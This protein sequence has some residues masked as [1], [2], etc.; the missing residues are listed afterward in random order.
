MKALS[1]H[2]PW[3][4][5]IFA[6]IKKH[7]TR[8]WKLSPAVVGVPIAL[9]AAKHDSP[10]TRVHWKML[11]L[12]QEYEVASKQFAEIG[13]QDYVELPRGCILGIVR[14]GAP[15]LADSCV[16]RTLPDFR[17]GDYGP[18]R[19]FWPV[20]VL[21]RFSKPVPCVGMQG[22]FNWERSTA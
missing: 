8:S 6:G 7:E 12:D 9:H 5:A 20:E 15:Y 17:W 22:F 21:E 16:T 10:E 13:I 1:L 19:Y 14:F 4:S 3:A 2:Q 11:V 18:N